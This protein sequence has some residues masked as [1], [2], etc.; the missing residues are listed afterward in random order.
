MTPVGGD[1]RPYHGEQ[2]GNTGAAVPHYA[3]RLLVVGDD[4]GALVETLLA[5]PRAAVYVVS[6]QSPMSDVRLERADAVI[7]PDARP[8]PFPSSFFDAAILCPGSGTIV[9]SLAVYGPLV[10]ANGALVGHAPAG[11]QDG[12]AGMFGAAGW[13]LTQTW[14]GDAGGQVYRA[15]RM[16]F[17]F[18]THA[19]ALFESGS[20][21][22]AYDL[23][24]AIPLGSAEAEAAA[25]AA[26]A[27]FYLSEMP[28]P[29]DWP[30]RLS[31]FAR[32]HW[33]FS[34]AM[35]CFPGE[36]QSLRAMAKIAAETG[37]P[38][39]AV[40]LLAAMESDS[41]PDAG[42][43]SLPREASRQ[44]IDIEVAGAGRPIETVLFLT[45][46]QMDYGLDTLYDGLCAL[47]GD[48]KVTEY[49]FKSSLHQG[50]EGVASYYPSVFHRD[51]QP[52]ALGQ[53]LSS[54]K[55]GGYDLILFGDITHD[56]PRKV[57]LQL[58]R[59]NRAVPVAIVDQGDSPEDDFAPLA[60]Y[61]GRNDIVRYF[62]REKLSGVPYHP[63]VT[64]LPFSYPASRIPTRALGARKV[65]VYWAGRREGWLRRC[66][67]ERLE[68]FLGRSF[69]SVTDQ[70][71]YAACLL[72][73]QISPS[74]F[75]GGFDTVRYWEVP[76][77]GSLLLAERP[78]IEIANN[79]RDGVEA[80]FFDSPREFEEKLAYLTAHTEA[81]AAIAR[82]GRE[83]LLAHHTHVVRA[84][85]LL[86]GV[87]CALGG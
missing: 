42:L 78:P 39:L 63:R 46:S 74:F 33:L 27:L 12:L 10:Q 3:Q 45:R 32:A 25:F 26:D 68:R 38:D 19:R 70:Q 2:E 35:A 84:R 15:F 22:S 29:G 54:L 64:S 71:A 8:L 11:A 47:L 55:A 65:P 86:D 37:Q 73:A 59:A 20:A 13:R 58:T 72:A 48:E 18:L 31:R 23:L 5:R 41:A 83:K 62:K 50:D 1:N 14:P 85:Q 69:E 40:G 49:P 79:F 80:V 81:C 53:I 9:E 60:D 6:S 4:T 30:A 44:E 43:L 28:A 56:T 21:T 51:G 75:G 34:H 7:A 24:Y 17:N 77:H 67:L 87:Q 57:I 76:A 16:D 36:S 61:L 66:Y 82:A 52:E